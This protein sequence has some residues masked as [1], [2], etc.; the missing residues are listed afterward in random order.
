VEVNQFLSFVE[1]LAGMP[2]TQE[3]DATEGEWPRYFN[4][5]LVTMLRQEMLSTKLPMLRRDIRTIFE[6]L[7]A[8][9]PSASK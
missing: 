2:F 8:R 1:L 7:A 9:A 5:T 6:K 4:K 3:A